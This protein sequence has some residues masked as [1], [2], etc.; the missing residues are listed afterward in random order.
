MPDWRRRIS[1]YALWTKINNYLF[2]HCIIHHSY[3][4]LT[5]VQTR[6]FS[7]TS[8]KISSIGTFNGRFYFILLWG[9]SWNCFVICNRSTGWTVVSIFTTY[10]FYFPVHS[11]WFEGLSVWVIWCVSSMGIFSTVLTPLSI[12]KLWWRHSF[13][14]RCFTFSKEPSKVLY[15]FSK[16]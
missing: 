2:I 13:L 10:W 8:H 16:W 7:C 15:K 1:L 4:G 9:A 12:H 11:L 14:V 5:V 6:F 3:L